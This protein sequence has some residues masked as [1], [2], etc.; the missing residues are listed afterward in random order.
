MKEDEGRVREAEEEEARALTWRAL[1]DFLF[2]YL[3]GTAVKS[4]E[5]SGIKVPLYHDYHII[6]P[7]WNLR[8]T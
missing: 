1:L 4:I 8:V 2:F 7:S 3:R 5:L 6:Q